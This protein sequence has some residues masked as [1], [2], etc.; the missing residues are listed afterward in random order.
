MKKF[1]FFPLTEESWKMRIKE[2]HALKKAFGRDF[3]KKFIKDLKSKLKEKKNFK[4]LVDGAV[5]S[6]K[7]YFAIPL[8]TSLMKG[9]GKLSL[10]NVVCSIEQFNKKISLNKPSDIIIYDREFYDKEGILDIVKKSKNANVIIVACSVMRILEYPN[11]FDYVLECIV[12]SEKE[13][14]VYAL[15]QDS[16]GEWKGVLKL[17]KP[18]ESFMRKYRKKFGET[19]IKE[20][21]ELLK[22]KDNPF[23]F[24]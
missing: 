3:T 19:I 8:A 6:E 11:P 21:K 14:N 15:V 4:I 2:N 22:D 20:R 23:N 13:K 5:S 24:K 17:L 7:D 9:L 1:K 10:S 12:E 16:Y 18:S